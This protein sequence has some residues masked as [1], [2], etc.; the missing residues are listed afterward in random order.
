MVFENKLCQ[1]VS[2]S[3]ILLFLYNIAKNGA[4]LYVKILRIRILQFWEKCGIMYKLDVR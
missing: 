4:V 2:L 1:S 3:K